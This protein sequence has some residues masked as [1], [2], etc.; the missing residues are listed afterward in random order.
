MCCAA[1]L[2]DMVM[3]ITDLAQWI[4]VSNVVSDGVQA[5]WFVCFYRL[6]ECYAI[7]LWED[8]RY[9]VQWNARCVHLAAMWILM[10]SCVSALCY[11]C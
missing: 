1:F 4:S 6:A 10:H 8:C 3:C 11:M 5:C 2:F 9:I 7:G